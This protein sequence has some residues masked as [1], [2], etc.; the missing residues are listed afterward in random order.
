MIKNLVFDWSGVVND[1][2][3]TVHGV[4]NKLFIHFGAKEITLNEFMR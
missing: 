3:K 1:N 4:V 2:I